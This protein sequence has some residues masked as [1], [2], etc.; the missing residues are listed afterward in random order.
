MQTRVFRFKEQARRE[1]QHVGGPDVDYASVAKHGNPLARMFSDNLFQRIDHRGMKRMK[2]D[3]IVVTSGNVGSPGFIILCLEFLHG[4]V[5]CLLTI[6]FNDPFVLI[7]LKTLPECKRFSRLPCALHGA[8]VHRVNR[9]VR[10]PL[11][12]PL[13]LF[14]ADRRQRRV[15]LAV[16]KFLAFRQTVSNE[17]QFQ[18]LFPPKLRRALFLKC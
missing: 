13:R 10:Q 6:V 18:L 1:S 5:A 14:L 17:Y 3:V 11:R 4:N 16:W 2:V 7:D 9:F 8:G 15:G 12:Y